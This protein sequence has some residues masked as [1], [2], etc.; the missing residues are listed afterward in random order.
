MQCSSVYNTP[1]SLP[2]LI[3]VVRISLTLLQLIIAKE[4]YLKIFKYFSLL[5]NLFCLSFVLTLC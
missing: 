4:K 5:Y 1:W 2:P 3:T